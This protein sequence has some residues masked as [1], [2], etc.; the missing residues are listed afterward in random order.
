MRF[1]FSS[2]QW[3]LDL[4]RNTSTHLPAGPSPIEPFLAHRGL[5]PRTPLFPPCS[6]P[7]QQ[8]EKR[9][10]LPSLGSVPCCLSAAVARGLGRSLPSLP[11]ALTLPSGAHSSQLSWGRG[12]P[13]TSRE[14]RLS[15][16]GAWWGRGWWRQQ[17]MVAVSDVEAVGDEPPPLLWGI[18]PSKPS[19][20]WNVTLVPWLKTNKTSGRMKSGSR[21]ERSQ[22]PFSSFVVSCFQVSRAL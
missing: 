18:S 9:R 4:G 5:A 8:L 13:V 15:V 6:H 16:A 11:S 17:V 20:K 19:R 1:L 3:G 10:D 22:I 14:M 2:T 21:L 7:S 12:R